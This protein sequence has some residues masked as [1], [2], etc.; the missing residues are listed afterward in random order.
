MPEFQ[1]E[2]LQRDPGKLAP[3]FAARRQTAL[4]ANYPIVME[5]NATI[6]APRQLEDEAILNTARRNSRRGGTEISALV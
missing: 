4:P 1:H 5:M 6:S 3:S 2:R